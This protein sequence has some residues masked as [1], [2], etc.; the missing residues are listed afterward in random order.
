MTYAE[1][2]DVLVK[3]CRAS[4]TWGNDPV[5]ALDVRHIICPFPIRPAQLATVFH[6]CGHLQMGDRQ[7]NL[8]TWRQEIRA[9]RWA[10]AEWRRRGL[11]HED[12][13]QWS[14]SRALSTHLRDAIVDGEVT[15]AEILNAVPYELA[16][17]CERLELGLKREMFKPDAFLAEQGPEPER[18]AEFV[19][20]GFWGP[21]V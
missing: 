8:P 10:L 19:P 2:A 1:I 17:Y 6:E 12:D 14:L 13:C 9:S 4:V 16:M 7:A 21:P 15:R 3:E 20:N 18:P 5:A 11:A